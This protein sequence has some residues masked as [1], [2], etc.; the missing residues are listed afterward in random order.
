MGK[1]RVVT[2]DPLLEVLE[3]SRALG[4][5]GPGPVAEHVVHA[6]GLV[7]L[8]QEEGLEPACRAI[9][10]GS[11]GGVP[12]LVAAMATPSWRWVLLDSMVRRTVVLAEAVERLGLGDRVEVWCERAEETG[13]SERGRG[14]FDVVTARSFAA[15]AVTAE[16]AAPLLRLGG[17]L[18]V[19]EP[20]GSDGSRWDPAP[21]ADL[22]FTRAPEIVGS[23]VVHRLHGPV[24]DWAPRPV[25]RPAKRPLWT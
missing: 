10:L 13:R 1:A 15:P 20:P 5:L 11:G 17:R 18:V 8:L 12:G 24:P 16:C 2:T 14:A 21:M 19:S 7:D 25:G 4:F 3:R 23:W 6:Q 9:D 22:G